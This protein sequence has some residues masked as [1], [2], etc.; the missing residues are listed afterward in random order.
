M[1]KNKGNTAYPK[2]E[3]SIVCATPKEL[4]LFLFSIDALIRIGHLKSSDKL[5]WNTAYNFILASQKKEEDE[6]IIIPFNVVF[7]S[8]TGLKNP[9]YKIK[10]ATLKFSKSTRTLRIRTYESVGILRES[11][12]THADLKITSKG[13]VYDV[14][15]PNLGEFETVKP[16]HIIRSKRKNNNERHY[17]ENRTD[18][19][20]ITEI[21]KVYSWAFATN[22]LDRV[23]AP[24]SNFNKKTI[25]AM[26][27]VE[28]GTLNISSSC[29]DDSKLM[30]P[31]DKIV[32][33]YLQSA[34]IQYMWSNPKEFISNTA[35]NR[36]TFNLKDC[37][38]STGTNDSGMA[39]YELYSSI[40][41]I[42]GNKFDLDG[43]N[44]PDFMFEAGF[45]DNNENTMS[46]AR[47]SHLSMIGETEDTE[48]N[49]SEYSLETK[50]EIK[51]RDV[52]LYVTLSIPAMLYLPTRKA[53]I[54]AD[55]N[56]DYKFTRPTLFRN[57]DVLNFKE[58]SGYQDTLSDYLKSKV[59]YGNRMETKLKNILPKWLEANKEQPAFGV[60]QFFRSL[61]SCMLYFKGKSKSTRAQHKYLQCTGYFSEFVF[62]CKVSNNSTGG[63]YAHLDYDIIFHHVYPEQADKIKKRI[64]KINSTRKE[65]PSLFT[66]CLICEDEDFSK[67]LSSTMSEDGMN[68]ARKVHESNK[69]KR[70]VM[71]DGLLFSPSSYDLT[72]D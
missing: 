6:S 47:Y 61:D 70:D 21:E 4:K 71:V 60:F 69:S 29:F 12:V 9:D 68:K 72:I 33:K 51:Q 45:V 27:H 54:L 20:L 40:I 46:R 38:T 10:E 16:S 5:F 63:Q 48:K 35:V 32:A 30:T 26:L 1:I 31:K 34:A 14:V 25:E 56:K 43:S 41:R 13:K 65:N 2:V 28:N 15:N 50:D 3:G 22:Y 58:V 49:H 36:F 42:C 64:V 18:V 44:C 57:N 52:P 62:E 67:W 66:E 11:K 8:I 37:L 19:S 55:Q 24:D 17:Y 53:L 7:D 59:I 23:L 39:R